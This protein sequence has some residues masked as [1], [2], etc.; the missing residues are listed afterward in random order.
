MS[1]TT[2]KISYNFNNCNFLRNRELGFK[3]HNGYDDEISRK[4]YSN[5]D[6]YVTETPLGRIATN[7]GGIFNLEFS[8][9]G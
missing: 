9:D 2:K 1:K 3:R 6:A 5:L 4:L 8:Q 7:Q